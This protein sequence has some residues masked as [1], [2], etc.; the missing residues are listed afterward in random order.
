[1]LFVP[2]FLLIVTSNWLFLVPGPSLRLTPDALEI[3]GWGLL[4]RPTRYP[5][6]DLE[7]FGSQRGNLLLTQRDKICWRFRPGH[8]LRRGDSSI[9]LPSEPHWDRKIENIY[10]E[11]QEVVKELETWRQGASA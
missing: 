2:F 9:R 4:I 7:S 3:E 8:P 11:T 10:G 6:R 1:L 5:R